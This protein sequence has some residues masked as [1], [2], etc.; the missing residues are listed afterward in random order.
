MPKEIMATITFSLPVKSA[1]W[2]KRLAKIENKTEDQLFEDMLEL[3]SMEAIDRIIHE[4]RAEQA[5][6]KTSG[7]LSDEEIEK[8]I[9]EVR[10]KNN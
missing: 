8:M 7:S 10:D 1:D 9:R 2:I 6:D 3:Y 5:A 4:F